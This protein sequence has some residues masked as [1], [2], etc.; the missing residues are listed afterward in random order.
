MRMHYIF[1]QILHLY[2]PNSRVP[3]QG[4]WQKLWQKVFLQFWTGDILYKVLTVWL[5]DVICVICLNPFNW[6]LM[7][8]FTHTW[9][10]GDVADLQLEFAG[11]WR[12][13]D[14]DL[15]LKLVMIWIIFIA[16]L[17]PVIGLVRGRWMFTFQGFVRKLTMNSEVE[18]N[19][20]DRTSKHPIHF[21]ISFPSVLPI[22]VIMNKWILSFAVQNRY[23]STRT[24]WKTGNMELEIVLSSV[25]F[26][27]N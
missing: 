11:L 18:D 1:L 22:Q 24:N 21:W 3:S 10:Y 8:I 6:G 9:A 19:L 27:I 14:F 17:F 4:Y 23:I 20:R 25:A 7:C 5:G 26:L 15:W 13:Y 2:C 16:S 12:I